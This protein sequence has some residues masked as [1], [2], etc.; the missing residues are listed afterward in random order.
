MPRREPGA[1]RAAER[2]RGHSPAP[3]LAPWTPDL[4]REIVVCVVDAALGKL[5]KQA[6][7]VSPKAVCDDLA[8][9]FSDTRIAMDGGPSDTPEEPMNIKAIYGPY[10]TRGLHLMHVHYLDGS[11]KYPSFPTEEEA[12]LFKQ[13]SQRR[14]VKN[15]ISLAAAI[16]KYIEQRT[17]I[18]ENSRTTLKFRLE[19]LAKDH[20]D[21]LLQAFSAGRAWERVE[22]C[23][24]AVDTRCGV[25]SAAK[26]FFAWC[27][28]RG[29]LKHDPLGHVEIKGRKKRGKQQLY[30][31]EA[32]KLLERT[33]AAAAG[34]K[35]AGH[36][37]SQQDVALPGAAAALL[38]GLRS[39]EVWSR[40]VRD[41][42]D[43]G[44]VLWVP[45]SKTESGR[46]RLEVP[47]VLRPLLG[48]LAEGKDPTDLL[49]P[50]LTAGGLRYWTKRLCKDLKLPTVCPQGLR[51]THASL[52]FKPHTNP[53]EV[54]AALGH[55][56]PGIT[57]RHYATRQAVSDARQQAVVDTLVPSKSSSN[58]PV[59]QTNDD[60]DPQAD[61]S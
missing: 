51:G 44:S 8:T 49:F 56:S 46:R 18:Q 36:D 34:E 54:A 31:T 45:F 26:G 30:V 5:G 12:L 28:E 3:R 50:G 24:P 19:T 20:G 22:K 6:A 60:D 23:C 37:D 48:K 47:E 35:L 7:V 9:P 43:D 55:A 15:P 53:H 33:V 32:R 29:W 16:G 61:A 27:I 41:L 39:F 1:W 11:K 57:Y 58:T 59:L 38:L 2:S 40:Q 21:T 13:K 10:T 14:I 17:D 25:R 42:D 4:L 52:S